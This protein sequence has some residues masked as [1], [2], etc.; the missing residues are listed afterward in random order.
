M[1][2]G[3]FY[4]HQLP[5]AVERGQRVPAA[6]GVARPR[7]SWPTGSATTTRGR[8]STT[9]SRS[10]RTPRR[11]RSSSG[12]A[13]QRTRRIRLGH[14]IIQLPTNHPIRVAERV[15]TL[16][17]LSG[18]RVELGLGEGQG[19]IELH[20]FGRRVSDKREMWEEAVR[21]L[22]PC[23][24]QD[25]VEFHGQF[26]DFPARNVIPK[27]LPE[28][29]PAALGR[30]LE[31]RDDRQRGAV[32]HGRARLPVRLAGGGARVGHRYYTSLTR[33][34]V[35][36]A[37]YPANPNIAMVS[38]FMCAPTDEEAREKAAGWT[39]FVFCL[40]HYGRHGMAEPGRGEH[41]GALPGVAEHAEG[42]GDAQ[43]GA[44]RLAGD[45][46][47]QARRVR[48]RP[49]WTRSSCS[50][51]RAHPPRG[52]LLEPRAVRA[53]GH[54]GV[55]RARG[56]ASAVEGRGPGRGASRSRSS[57]PTATRSTRTRTRT[58]SG[59]RP[60]GAQAQDG[61][62]GGRAGRRRPYVEP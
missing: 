25:A 52:H 61:G 50:T 3:I 15:A 27:P 19:P 6:P 58:S 40:S 48:G 33:G 13:S 7:S 20:P 4:E 54:A 46:P 32:G 9:S 10:T 23:F 43:R 29:A 37:D 21:V 5:A 26:F 38:A 42:A 53:R 24:T 47:A 14:G 51:R 44:D 2:F 28:A 8:S 57:T 17:L 34:P 30:V 62:Q 39:F 45:D 56:R 18:G 12:A 59:S 41:V 36:L 49:T 16:D 60:D 1:K 31:H 22:I 35:E 55:P 11:P